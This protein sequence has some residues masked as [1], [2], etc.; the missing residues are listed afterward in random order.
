MSLGFVVPRLTH[1]GRI[2]SFCSRWMVFIPTPYFSAACLE[3]ITPSG[4]LMSA[5]FS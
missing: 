5:L 1:Q 4:S 2:R 3:V